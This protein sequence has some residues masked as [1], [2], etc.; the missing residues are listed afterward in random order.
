MTVEELSIQLQTL[1]VR[2]DAYSLDGGSPSEA[3][4]L[5]HQSGH[6]EIY[7]SERGQKTGVQAFYSE[8]D[9]CRAFLSLIMDDESVIA[10]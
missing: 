7:Y 9:A 8:D 5:S 1:G 10:R 2:Q 4:C 6:W 3:Y